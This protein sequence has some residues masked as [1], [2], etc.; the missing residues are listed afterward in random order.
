MTQKAAASL[1]SSLFARKG[2][3][4]PASLLI[5]EM[6][7]ANGSAA[8]GRV[9]GSARRRPKADADLP[10]L[11]YVEA[12]TG[13]AQTGEA[14][15]ENDNESGEDLAAAAETVIQADAVAQP[16]P[17][18]DL[19]PAASL[20]DRGA[21]P[22]RRANGSAP[23]EESCTTP[24]SVAPVCAEADEVPMKRV[25]IRS[26]PIREVVRNTRRIQQV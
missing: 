16:A 15:S 25:T 2:K 10:L 22:L 8:P 20:L 9:N 19:P 5:S 7:A 3:A 23:A 26:R 18:A 13:E 1:S 11:A 24:E 14:E 17:K 4:S 12:Q 21:K 6:E